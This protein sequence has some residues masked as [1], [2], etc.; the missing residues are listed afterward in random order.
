[1]DGKWVWMQFWSD[2]TKESEQRVEFPEVKGIYGAFQA[3]FEGKIYGKKR[4]VLLM[5]SA[6]TLGYFMPVMSHAP[7]S[8]HYQKCVTT[9]KLEVFAI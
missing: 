9:M 3:S 1:M 2:H 8:E 6:I 7:K 4:S 5:R